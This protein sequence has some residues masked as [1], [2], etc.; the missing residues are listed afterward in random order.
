M[1]D[2]Q[3]NRYSRHLLLPQIDLDGQRRLLDS[4]ALIIGLGGLGSPAALYL[5]A[6][7]VGRITLSDPD[8][9]EPSNLQRQILYRTQDIGHLKTASAQAHLQ[10][11]NPDVLFTQINRKLSAQ[12]LVRLLPDIDVVIDASDNFPSRYLINEACVNSSTAL[13]IG[14]A[15]GL[16]GQ[17]TVINPQATNSACYRCLYPYAT[18]ENVESCAD[19]GVFSPLLGIIGSIQACEA[20]KILAGFGTTLENRL[21]QINAQTMQ[22]KCSSFSRE[23]TCPI[24]G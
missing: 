17:V 15:I 1:K 2:E 12:E 4:H 14:A 5:A 13:I 16:D 7:G 23:P 11:L 8:H 19:H 10:Q 21:L 24:C 9:I 3:L 6:S 20:L 22:I 18:E